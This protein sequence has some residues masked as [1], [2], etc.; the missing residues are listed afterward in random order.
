MKSG[1][2]KKLMTKLKFHFFWAKFEE[3]KRGPLL[4]SAK[5]MAEVKLNGCD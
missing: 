4:F 2:K 1:N 5:I 3:Q